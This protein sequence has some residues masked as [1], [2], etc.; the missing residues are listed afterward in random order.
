MTKMLMTKMKTMGSK[1]RSRFIRP[2]RRPKHP[3]VDKNLNKRLTAGLKKN[4]VSK[5]DNI[6]VIMMSK[7]IGMGA[8]NNIGLKA[9]KTDYAFVLNPDVRFICGASGTF[10]T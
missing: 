8:G 3:K 9:C 7:N 10:I 2:L 4:L 6:E 1:G 5:Y